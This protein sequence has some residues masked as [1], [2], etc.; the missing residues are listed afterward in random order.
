MKLCE[1]GCGLPAPLAKRTEKRKGWIQ[2]EPIRFIKNHSLGA[3]RLEWGEHLWAPEDRGFATPCWI[4]KFAISNAGYGVFANQTRI[5]N[6]RLAHRESFVRAKGTIPV[7]LTLD[8]LCGV[9]SCVRPDHLEPV[10]HAENVRRGKRARMTPAI[11]EEIFRL[12][13]DGL[14]QVSI[15]EK[16]GLSRSAVR[17][18]LVGKTWT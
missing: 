15:A 13:K 12:R 10:T 7:G 14:T 1:C 17:S 4:W 2:G 18:L 11:R 5:S 8:H 9:T 16:V 3:P 6:S